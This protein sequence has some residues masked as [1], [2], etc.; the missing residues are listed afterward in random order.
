[1]RA[2]RAPRTVHRTVSR[3]PTSVRTL[4]VGDKLR[5][6][7][8]DITIVARSASQTNFDRAKVREN[9]YR[10]MKGYYAKSSEPLGT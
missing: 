5:T 8:H 10:L 4:I 7:G 1:M 2:L 9:V 3:A 6:L